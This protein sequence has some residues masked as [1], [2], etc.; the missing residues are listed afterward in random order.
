MAKK[1]GIS[2]AAKKLIAGMVA[3]TIVAGAGVAGGMAIQT[4]YADPNAGGDIT[5]LETDLTTEK[6]SHEETKAKLAEV[7]AELETEKA[8]DIQDEA[9][10]AELEARVAE[11]EQQLTRDE[12]KLYLDEFYSQVP[13]TRL[14]YLDKDNALVYADN[15][16]GVY[17]MNNN[18]Y[19][20]TR[21]S[22]R[23]NKI[24]GY[25]STN[26]YVLI[27][28][29]D[30]D[31]PSLVYNKETQTI[32][33]STFD[34]N[35]ESIR[36]LN[37][38][39]LVLFNSIVESSQAVGIVWDLKT[40]T[41]VCRINMSIGEI[42]PIENNL[43]I[44]IDN[45][46]QADWHLLDV[47]AGTAS[48]PIG[49]PYNCTTEEDSWMYELSCVDTNNKVINF[50]AY[51]VQTGTLKGYQYNYETKTGSDVELRT[52]TLVVYNRA[53]EQSQVLE[54]YMVGNPTIDA[55]FLNNTSLGTSSASQFS[56]FKVLDSTTG[57]LVEVETDFVLD[58]TIT[59][60]HLYW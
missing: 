33:E 12:S 52:I 8:K 13:D 2:K 18:D 58:E 55:Y 21:V 51:N 29:S 42:R 47:D 43:Y 16:S 49:S 41:E 6:A 5:R 40:N 53:G 27:T 24:N 4:A 19:V 28:S 22:I 54:S 44:F 30:C 50:I 39:D 60:L 35:I 1:K 59:E 38:N 17:L 31:Y 3:T 56:M 46:N 48:Q 57:E 10:I 7:K 25:V 15:Y 36:S 20:M 45:H 34:F 9:R 14:I 32:S 23:G 11:L 26:N 37:N